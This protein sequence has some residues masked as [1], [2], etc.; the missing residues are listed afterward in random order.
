MG[1]MSQPGD[2]GGAS[3]AAS[4]A[5]TAPPGQPPAAASGAPSSAGRWPQGSAS[6][7]QEHDH[8]D[9]APCLFVI[10]GLVPHSRTPLDRLLTPL[11][12]G[13]IQPGRFILAR[14]TTLPPGSGAVD[15]SHDDRVVWSTPRVAQHVVRAAAAWWRPRSARIKSVRRGCAA[16]TARA[17]ACAPAANKSAKL[18]QHPALAFAVKY[19]LPDRVIAASHHRGGE[20]KPRV[21]DHHSDVVAAIPAAAC[22]AWWARRET[23]LCTSSPCSDHRRYN[24]DLRCR[25]ARRP[26]PSWFGIPD[27]HASSA[28]A[29]L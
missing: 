1:A 10:T 27:S 12:P 20:H 4:A 23:R 7:H 16:S 17:G 24:A 22:S 18:R 14:Q 11:R 19:R 21:R 28:V 13:V 6:K 29:D 26:R 2:D 5:I 9:D 3:V 8:D 25:R 15:L